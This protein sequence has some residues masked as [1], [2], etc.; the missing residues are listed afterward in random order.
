MD[1]H[2]LFGTAVEDLPELPDLVPEAHRVHRRQT[3]MM[4][5]SVVAGTAALVIGVGTLTIAA[6]WGK[7]AGSTAIGAAGPASTSASS[8]P[9]G[10]T[11]TGFALAA[12]RALEASLPFK[13]ATVTWAPSKALPEMPDMDYIVTVGGKS[14]LLD[15]RF[16][17]QNLG[18]DD[19]GNYPP[20]L[21]DTATAK[22]CTGNRYSYNADVEHG[23]LGY[24]VTLWDNG[25]NLILVDVSGDLAA[26]MTTKQAQDWIMSAPM[27]QLNSE[28]IAD[29]QTELDLGEASATAPISPSPT[30]TPQR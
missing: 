25:L 17:E 2:E 26:D 13:G 19:Q 12:V 15:F 4:R 28:A 16:A 24:Q 10:P 29:H 21:C 14:M 27:L 6:P 11:P 20:K 18:P 3:T 1:L 8:A 7:P 5:S 23:G 30:K 22:N 9:S